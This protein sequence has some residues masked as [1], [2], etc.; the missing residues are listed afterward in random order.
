MSLAIHV[1]NLRVFYDNTIVLDKVSWEVK[2]GTLAAII[3]PNGGG[4]S[5]FLKS[6]LGMIPIATGEI[7]ILNKPSKLARPQVAY[8]PQGE[9]VDWHFPITCLDVVLQG[10][11]VHLKW[12]KKT[13]KQDVAKAYECLELVGMEKFA[14]R[15][16]GA[17]SGGQK[18]RV[19]IARALAQEAKI[20][21]LDEPATGLDAAA[22]H[23]LIDLFKKLQ[24]R[25]YTVV[26]TT[27]DL[28]CIAD[29]FDVVLGLNKQVILSGVPSEVIN[30]DVLNDLFAK[31]FPM[32]KPTGEVI[33]HD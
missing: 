17:L 33:F 9:E 30:A 20:I 7:R 8:L 32:V 21:M 3:G 14:N 12:W 16:I 11:L 13:N 1:E 25:G 15:P 24:K 28:N 23:D 5:T 26:V 22:Q 19:F 18:Q 29:C 4:K 31:H 6:L 2:Q 10:R 27:H